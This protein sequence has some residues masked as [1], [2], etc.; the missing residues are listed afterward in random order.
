M[1]VAPTAGEDD[2]AVGAS[3]AEVVA[4]ELLYQRFLHATLVDQGM[5]PSTGRPAP[6]STRSSRRSLGNQA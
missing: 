5:A 4:D 2:G 3:V 6:S 1:D